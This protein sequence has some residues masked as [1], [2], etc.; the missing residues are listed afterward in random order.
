M[1]NH[2]VK[3]KSVE[4]IRNWPFVHDRLGHLED[5]FRLSQGSGRDV[6]GRVPG[7]SEGPAENPSPRGNPTQ[8]QSPSPDP[9][10]S[11]GGAPFGGL[12]G[13][14]TSSSACSCV[15]NSLQSA[16]ASWKPRILQ[17]LEKDRRDLAAQAAS[18]PCPKEAPT[19]DSPVSFSSA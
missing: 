4:K 3:K 7:F 1:T 19:A 13:L 17:V 12:N 10:P 9:E 16:T 14:C 18:H 5:H 2:P 8:R 11:G 6:P 15:H